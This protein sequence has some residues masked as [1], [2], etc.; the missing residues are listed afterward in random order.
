MMCHKRCW[1]YTKL[2]SSFIVVLIVL[3]VIGGC[4]KAP[5]VEE[6]EKVPSNKNLPSWELIDASKLSYR[7][8]DVQTMVA[9]YTKGQEISCVP[10]FR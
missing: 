7:L 6:N 4:A 10:L 8:I 2:L 9:C 5:N 1:R 3:I